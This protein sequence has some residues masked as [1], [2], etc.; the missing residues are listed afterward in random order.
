MRRGQIDSENS[1]WEQVEI[2]IVLG[3]EGIHCFIKEGQT[4]FW[5]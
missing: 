3:C 5:G 1:N 2:N 4:Q